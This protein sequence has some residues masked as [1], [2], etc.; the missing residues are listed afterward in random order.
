MP[1]SVC[2]FDSGAV[3]ARS[4]YGVLPRPH[5]GLEDAI[6]PGEL[7]FSGGLRCQYVCVCMSV[8]QSLWVLIFL[9]ICV[10]AAARR[11]RPPRW[12]V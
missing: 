11:R 1:S 6:P 12:V 5:R 2:C 9:F 4:G 7:P 3:A 10:V 8:V